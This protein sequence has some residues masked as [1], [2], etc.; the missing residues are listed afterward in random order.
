MENVSE[1]VTDMLCG[2]LDRLAEASGDDLQAELSRTKAM[3]S[4]SAAIVGQQ[5][6]D[7]DAKR[8]AL[9]VIKLRHGITGDDQVAMYATKKM[10]GAPDEK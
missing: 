10:L 1:K 7:N 4:A 8:I 5:R 9:D 3:V 2:Q 6:A